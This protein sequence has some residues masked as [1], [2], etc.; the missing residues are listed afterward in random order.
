M[1]NGGCSDDG[2]AYF[3]SWLISR[4]RVVY[5]AAVR[6]PDSLAAIVDPGRDDYEFE[7]LWGVAQRIYEERTGEEPPGA[8]DPGRDEPAGRRWDFDDD[9]QRS[10]KLRK[11][12]ALY[13]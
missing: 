12:A 6:D 11:L 13:L 8:D 9:E 3:R 2:F 1:I 4:G 7:D 5:E 10:R